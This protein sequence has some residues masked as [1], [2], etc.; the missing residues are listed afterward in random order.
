METKAYRTDARSDREHDTLPTLVVFELS[1]DAAKQISKL[2]SIVKEHGLKLVEVFDSNARFM[3]DEQGAQHIETEL[4]ML[5]VSS[6]EFWFAAYLKHTQV[7]VLSERLPISELMQ[8]LGTSVD[9]IDASLLAPEVHA[10]AHS[11]DRKIQAKFDAARWFAQ[12]TDDDVLKLYRTGSG[13]DYAAD[14]VAEFMADHDP[15]TKAMF[16]YNLLLQRAGD[17]DCGFECH[18]D[19]RDA[20]AWIKEHRPGLYAQISCEANDVKL[21][22]VTDKEIQGRWDWDDGRGNVSEVSLESQ[23]AAA[24]DAVKVLSLEPFPR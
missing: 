12:A 16:D 19:P 22:E 11:N 20:I 1:N 2:A 4:G 17:Q 14:A 9:P 7:M 3:T 18:V 21:V 8:H 23:H 5:R 13:G 24:I 15:D 6:S 10:Q